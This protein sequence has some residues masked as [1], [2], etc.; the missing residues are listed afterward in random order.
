V[1]GPNV[2]NDTWDAWNWTYNGA[3][4]GPVMSYDGTSWFA[5]GN[6][7]GAFDIVGCGKLCKVYP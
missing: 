1:P 7:S 4:T 6:V 2:Q 3:Q 5:S